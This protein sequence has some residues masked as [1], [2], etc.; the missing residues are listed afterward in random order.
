MFIIGFEMD[1]FVIVKLGHFLIPPITFGGQGGF[2]GFLLGRSLSFKV[3]SEEELLMYP[4]FA[5]CEGMIS[6]LCRS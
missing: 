6:T 2:G 3:L 1:D 4:G 5:F